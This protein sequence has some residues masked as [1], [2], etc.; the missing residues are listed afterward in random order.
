MSSGVWG[1]RCV[2]G[3]KQNDGSLNICLL[4]YR[5]WG[6]W[7]YAHHFLGHAQL[8]ASDGRWSDVGGCGDP[9][10][11]KAFPELLQARKDWREGYG[12]EPICLHRQRV[13]EKGRGRGRTGLSGCSQGPRAYG[14]SQTSST[15]PACISP[16]SPILPYQ[17]FFQGLQ[18]SPPVGTPLAMLLCPLHPAH[19]TGHNTGYRVDCA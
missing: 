5:S 7:E 11:A 2:L 10:L 13:A 4:L 9:G 8:T 15:W 6:S 12:A 19:G 16:L 18:K 14:L 1:S 17:A 3:C